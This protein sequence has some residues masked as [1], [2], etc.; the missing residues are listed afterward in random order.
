MVAQPELQAAQAGHGVLVP[1]VERGAAARLLQRVVEAPRYPQDRRPEVRHVGAAWSASLRLLVVGKRCGVLVGHVAPEEAFCEGRLPAIWREAP[2]SRDRGRRGHGIP[3]LLLPPEQQRV[4]DGQPG[5]GEAE[6][7]I[8]P[9]GTRE[10]ALDPRNENAMARLGRLEL[11][12]RDYAA[13]GRDL[14]RA[15][16]IDRGAQTFS[17]GDTMWLAV[18]SGNP[19][20]A[21]AALGP[22]RPSALAA[23]EAYAVREIGIGWALDG[24]SRRRAIVDLRDRGRPASQ[25]LLAQA[26]DAWL[27]NQPAA[28][29]LAA[30]SAAIVLTARLATQGG[31]PALRTALAQALAFGGHREAAAVQIDSAWALESVRTNGFDGAMSGVLLAEAAALVGDRVRALRLIRELL[32]APGLLTPAWLRVDPY[33]ESLRGDPEFRRLA[34]G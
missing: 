33:F 2:C 25:V 10:V 1:R 14:G 23:A 20:G 4:I 11:W 27:R 34:G 13:A 32:E 17:L 6:T 21:R 22:V 5:P 29:R 30:D 9:Y 3:R 26:Q 7:G 19:G 12:L 18:A 8:Q 28:A 15:L 31:Q 24:D 16:A